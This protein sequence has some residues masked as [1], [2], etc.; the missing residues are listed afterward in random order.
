M[1]REI[2]PSLPPGVLRSYFFLAVVDAGVSEVFVES[3]RG[4]AGFEQ[5][6]IMGEIVENHPRQVILHSKIGGKRVVNMPLGE[7]LPRIC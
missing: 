7:Q 4:I 5:A 3:L 2:L 6:A 1:F